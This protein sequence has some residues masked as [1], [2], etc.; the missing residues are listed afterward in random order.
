MRP[1]R[2]GASDVLEDYGTS[3]QTQKSLSS[4][5]VASRRCLKAG[6][7]PGNDQLGSRTTDEDHVS[8]RE[9]LKKRVLDYF[10]QDFLADAA[11]FTAVRATGLRFLPRD[12]VPPIARSIPKVHHVPAWDIEHPRPSQLSKAD[13]DKTV[14]DN[15]QAVTG[16]LLVKLKL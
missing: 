6:W 11:A 10:K 3:I 2:H 13:R 4:I 8:L 12:K 16:R 7:R 9:S 14:F 1:T 5:S 15:L